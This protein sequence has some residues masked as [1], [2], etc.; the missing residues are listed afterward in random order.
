MTDLL[1]SPLH[2]TSRRARRQARRLRRLGD[3]D[4]V[5][6][7]PAA[8]CSREHTAV[9]DAVGLFDV[10]HLGK[11]TVR[12]PGARE[13]VNSCLTNDLGRIAP[14][15]AQYTL[16]CD[17]SGGVV[18]DL[19]AYLVSDDEVFLVPNAANTAEVVAPAG[20]RCAG[21]DRGHRTSTRTSACSRCRAR[22]RPTCSP[23]S[24]LPADLDYMAYADAT[25]AGAPVRIC[26][27]GYTGE[28]GY[29]LI[30]VL[31]RRACAV[32]RARGRG[33]P[34]RRHAG[35]AGCP[36]HVAHRDGLPAARSGPVARHLAGAGARGWA[37]GWRKDDFWGREAL[38]RR[39]TAG[40]A[41]LLW[42]IEALDRGIPARTCQCSALTAR[43]SAR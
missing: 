14:G 3:A 20:G 38:R 17:E 33:A 6:G 13:F 18:D 41:R 34:P 11:A 30:P 19:I 42:G 40:P 24:D 36:R 39:R 15:K 2:D 27:T 23:R 21:R 29:E 22:A 5:R 32:G 4:R 26:R 9:R 37:V 1:H 16:C 31:G 10:S 25:F 7:Q 43:S 28:H 12:G 8:G 35:R